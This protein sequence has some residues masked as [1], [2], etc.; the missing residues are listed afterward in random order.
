[1]LDAERAV[2]SGLFPG[3][4]VTEPYVVRLTLVRNLVPRAAAPR[5]MRG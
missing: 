3:G 4:A 2:L 1:M 5:R